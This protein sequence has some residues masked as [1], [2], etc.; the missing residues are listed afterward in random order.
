MLSEEERVQSLLEAMERFENRLGAAVRN[1][2][3]IKSVLKNLTGRGNGSDHHETKVLSSL[4][5]MVIPYVRKLKESR[6]DDEREIYLELLETNL[7]EMMTPFIAR[8]NSNHMNLTPRE[9]QVALLVRD[10]RTTK[11]IA[12]LLS[13]CPGAIDLHRSNI[14]KKLGLT[15]RKINLR[16]SLLSLMT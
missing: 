11:E 2:E 5:N 10:G 14:R 1:I 13:V 12:N 15:N 4:K 9:F 7:K 8:I 6:C 16:S 3:E